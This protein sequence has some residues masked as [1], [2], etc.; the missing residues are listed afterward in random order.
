MAKD[1]IYA[2]EFTKFKDYIREAVGEVK[3]RHELLAYYQ[4][5]VSK[6]DPTDPDL[7]DLIDKRDPTKAF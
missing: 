3:L 4:V 2:I 7:Y 6:I 5:S 1:W